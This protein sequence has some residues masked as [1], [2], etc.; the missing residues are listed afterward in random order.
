MSTETIGILADLAIALSFVVAVIFGIAEV[1]AAARDRRERFTLETL[2][3]FQT[4]EFAE[5]MQFINAR[6]LPSTRKAMQ[7]LPDDEQ[8][9]YI[10]FA[11]EM[12][13]LGILV[14]ERLIDIRLVDIALGNYV[15]T[16]WDRYK[17][18]YMDIRAKAPDPFLGEYF[19][20]LAERMDERMKENPRKPFYQTQG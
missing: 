2:R 14:A 1:R 20:W 18:L 17:V 10:Q 15:I 19:Q 4:R 16:T 5:L 9:R 3:Q 13:S 6:D 7:A 12:E 8:A 11:Q